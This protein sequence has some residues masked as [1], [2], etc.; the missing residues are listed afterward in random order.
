MLV[1]CFAILICGTTLFVRKLNTATNATAINI[2]L[3]VILPIIA[4]NYFVAT[5]FKNRKLNIKE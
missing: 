4:A 5:Y 3:L 1:S 2:F